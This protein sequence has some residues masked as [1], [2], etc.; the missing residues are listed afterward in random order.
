M[1][2]SNPAARSMTNDS[3]KPLEQEKPTPS[4]AGKNDRLYWRASLGQATFE[5]LAAGRTVTIEALIAH[6]QN[7]ET[8]DHLVLTNVS[9]RA[10][11]GVLRSLAEP[12]PS[13]DD[14][15]P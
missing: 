9:T 10:A 4:A 14:A 2:L 6:L 13:V 11:I 3:D 7:T 5:L 1:L 8:L 15:A 12:A